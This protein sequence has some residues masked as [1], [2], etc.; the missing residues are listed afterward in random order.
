MGCRVTVGR[1]NRR[2]ET[3]I[4]RWGPVM[5]RYEQ[6]A[7]VEAAVARVSSSRMMGARLVSEPEWQNLKALHDCFGRES[8]L[9]LEAADI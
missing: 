5:T 6:E 1:Y 2:D 3:E 9:V 7:S 8:E 4:D